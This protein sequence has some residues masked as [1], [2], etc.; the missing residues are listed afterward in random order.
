MENEEEVIAPQNDTVETTETVEEPKF[1]EAEMKAH[2]RAKA[3]EAKAKELKAQLKAL[4]EQKQTNA[5]IQSE[6][7]RLIARG[8]SDDEIDQAKVIAKGKD[9]SLTEALKDPMFIAFQKEMKENERKEK[10][11][12]GAS[13]GSNQSEDALAY[14]PGM[15]TDE[16]KALFREVMGK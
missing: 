10:A 3:A 7:L 16:H 13:K 2:A 1:T 6:E 5:P 11:K 14:K 12:L 15:T 4:Q 8:L 9:V